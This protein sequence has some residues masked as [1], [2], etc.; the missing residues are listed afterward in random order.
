MNARVFQLSTSPGG[1]P[2]YAVPQSDVQPLGLTGD[3]HRNMQVHGGPDKAVLLVTLEGI[4]EIKAAGFDVYPG[5]MGENITTEG[6]DR[7]TLRAGQRYR[8]GSDVIVELTKPRSPCVNLEAIWHGLGKVIYD[9]QVKAQN[10][11]SP[12]WALGGFYARV[13]RP[14][15]L[16]PGAPVL[17]MD[18][19]V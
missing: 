8:L 14:G 10:A 16:R 13:T 19:D 6:L 4:E 12:R 18:Q 5:G 7:R 2:K 15:A 17:L 3:R 1:M 11:E 9:A